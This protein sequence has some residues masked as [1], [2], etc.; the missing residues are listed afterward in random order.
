MPTGTIPERIHSARGSRFHR[1]GGE[2]KE[3]GAGYKG[4]THPDH[5]YSPSFAE[6]SRSRVVCPV[7]GLNVWSRRCVVQLVC[8][9]CGVPSGS[10]TEVTRD[11]ARTPVDNVMSRRFSSARQ[12]AGPGDAVCH[13]CRHVAA[14]PCL[15]KLSAISPSRQLGDRGRRAAMTQGG[16]GTP[17][18]K[19]HRQ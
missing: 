10:C 13:P 11:L 1:P 6:V 12:D 18:I 8:G 4:T 16:G 15:C 9:V 7:T 2:R 17:K 14:P 5:A 19:D 3:G